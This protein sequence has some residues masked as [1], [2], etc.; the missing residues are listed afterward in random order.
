MINKEVFKNS[1]VNLIE[2]F[3]QWRPAIHD[4]SPPPPI[5]VHQIKVTIGRMKNSKQWTKVKKAIQNNG[6]HVVSSNE[7]YFTELG[8][9]NW[10]NNFYA[11][12]KKLQKIPENGFF[13]LTTCQ[14]KAFGAKKN[15]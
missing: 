9:K 11:F 1:I 3:H 14:E 2:I 4:Y 8:P 6:T 10:L 13:G 7:L 15:P 5:A 12:P